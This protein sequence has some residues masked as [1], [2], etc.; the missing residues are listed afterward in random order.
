MKYIGAK[1]RQPTYP[2]GHSLLIYIHIFDFGSFPF[3]YLYFLN[4]N[5]K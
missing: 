4:M 2:Q 3:I 1:S 5:E